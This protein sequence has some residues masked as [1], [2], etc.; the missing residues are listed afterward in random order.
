M[1]ARLRQSPAEGWISLGLVLLM[2][3]TVAWSLDDAA[4][5]LG[6]DAYTDFLTLTVILGVL[7]GFA[8][9]KA[10]WGR[11][12][13]YLAGSF[14]AALIVPVYVG[15]VLLPEGDWGGQFR[16]TADA[17]TNAWRDLAILNRSVTREF[18]HFLLVLGLFTWATAM[19][20]SFTTFG[21]RRPLNAIILIGL[22][23]VGNMAFTFR[24]QLV[25][26]VIFSL[27][28]LF[29][30]VRFH[31]LDE[32]AEWIRRRIGDP[33]SI[34]AVYLRG[35]TVFIAFAVV[36]S[37]LLTQTASSAP[38]ASAWR[39]IGDRVL[40]WGRDLQRYLPTGGSNR[41]FGVSFGSS[42]QITGVWTTDSALAATIQFPSPET[43]DFYW[44][45]VSFNQFDLTGWS[46]TAVTEEPRPGN[47][48]LL[49]E[50]YA[51]WVGEDGRRTVTFTVIPENYRGSNV[52]SPQMPL[53]VDEDVNLL[54][55]GED[56]Y[57]SA[58]ERGG[59][60]PYTVSALVPVTGDEDPLGLTENRLRVAGTDYPDEVSALYLEVPDGAMPEDGAAVALL[61]EIVA[62]VP[63]DNPYDI[64]RTME[65]YLK[66]SEFRY[67]T[68]VR[69][70][71]CE[72]LSTVECFA[73]FRE[74]YCEYYASTMAILLRKLDIPTRLA[75]GFL[76]G[77]R[78][79][80][81][82]EPIYNN[83]AHAWVEVYFPGY[84]W[85]DFDPTGGPAPGFGPLPSG[86]PQQGPVGSFSARPIPPREPIGDTF[87]PGANPGIGGAG[88][89][90]AG[91]AGPLI[92]AAVL[93]LIV[94]GGLAFIAWQ[95]GPRGP[96]TPDGAY[97]MLTRLAGRLGFGPR[98][99]QTVY[100]Y[101]GALGELL[102]QSRPEIHTV[103]QAKV[104]VAYGHRLL[105]DD[106]LQSLR[107]A[108]RRLRIGLLRLL[109][110]RGGRRP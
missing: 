57:F 63:D 85:V 22:I 56:G 3:L 84:G 102:P 2:T 65:T 96:V 36:G 30:L 82:I 45:A 14:V 38:L 74:G 93:L 27:A 21:H 99:T 108:Q 44:R 67:D 5:V 75:E 81:G 72:R 86:E 91:T 50:A 103:A 52:L 83:S 110:K 104:E 15:A 43:R 87:V 24:D 35:G 101:A 58:V 12:A 18:G 100:E 61:D 34:S 62:L 29:L 16:A 6:R 70:L 68:D 20:A 90:N 28:A 19:Y 71:A 41:A 48:P 39:G 107:D 33:S 53:S 25:Y 17:V 89:T 51:D 76:P 59:E 78:D 79:V 98:P 47:E 4:W 11:W 105:G 92:A 49:T 1:M 7:A 66:S 40:E 10:G 73:L 8:G 88:T 46:R 60:G 37:L 97:G 13:T 106:R 26:L 64:A 77:S 80:T 109:L 31:V 32:Q 54:T 55:I 94:I 95:R 69:D 42:T 9:A 23:L